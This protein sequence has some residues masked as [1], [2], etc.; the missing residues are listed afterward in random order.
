MYEMA[1]F[2]AER[3][4]HGSNY[5]LTLSGFV[6]S[7]TECK[8]VCGDG[9]VTPD[10]VCDDGTNDG[11]YGSCAPG[12]QGRG[13]FCGDGILQTD[14][15]TCDD[16]VNLSPYGGCAP[17]CVAGGSCGDGKVDSRFGEQCDDG[18]NAGDYGGCGKTCKLG[19]RCGDG[20]KQA[21]FGEQCDDGNTS[22]GD[23][24]TT[25]CRLRVPQ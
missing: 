14:H 15:E 4:T 19:P 12:C 18:T 25:Q 21:A 24:C 7:V 20:V 13:P 16:G 6:K 3:H 9:I 5:K 23:T 8:S 1:L 22:N 11:S 2:Q 10:E 17:G